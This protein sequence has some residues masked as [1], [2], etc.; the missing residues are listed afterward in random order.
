MVY[1]HDTIVAERNFYASLRVTQGPSSY[2]G[3]TVLTL[4]NGSIRHG[5]Q[6]FGNNEL[7]HTP[8][9]YYTM[10]SGVGLAVRFCCEGRARNIG[11][12]GLG[13]GTL[14]RLWPPRRPYPLLRDQPGCSGHCAK[15]FHLHPRLRCGGRDHRRG[16]PHIAGPG[17]STALRCS[18]RRRILGRRDPHPS[19][20]HGSSGA[21]PPPPYSARHP[22]IPH[23]K[24][25]R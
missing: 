23:L 11:V 2:P 22:G 5:T 14:A 20:D 18:R 17:I 10:G 13:A 12:I 16:R 3:T 15:H 7:R 4:T 19:S 24:P 8:T 9:T 1:T 25:A 6:I 21:L